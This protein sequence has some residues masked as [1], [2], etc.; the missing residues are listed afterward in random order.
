M[1]NYVC[2]VIPIHNRVNLTLEFLDEFKKQTYTNF[3]VVIVNSGS[4]DN[5]ISEIS[6]RYPEIVILNTSENTWWS[7]ATN[8]GV[9]YAIEKQFDYVLTI[10]NDS[11][12]SPTLLQSLINTAKSHPNS[13]IGSRV[14]FE[15]NKTIWAIGVNVNFAQYP[16]LK[17]NQYGEVFTKE[18]TQKQVIETDTTV[19][20]GT[21]I[22]MS[23]FSKIGLFNSTWAPQYHGDTEFAYRSKKF[24]YNCIVD[25][26]AVILNKF[27]V[28]EPKFTLFDELFYKKSR[29][30]WRPYFLFYFKYAPLK[31]K[32]NLLRQFAWIKYHIRNWFI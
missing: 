4:T 28:A 2:V 21:L 26:N 8:I 19:G 13:L 12:P 24:G 6:N 31:Y 1:N 23:A 14:M 11:K 5:S 29:N 20:N 7:E 17:L 30:Y 27:F 3:Q 10:N 18:N 22:P 9:K 25:L 15:N 16:F 32:L